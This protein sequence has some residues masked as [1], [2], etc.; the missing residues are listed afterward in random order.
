MP[1]QLA[2]GGD[3]FVVCEEMMST[4]SVEVA[5]TSAGIIWR[6][7]GRCRAQV[8]GGC[9]SEGVECGCEMMRSDGWVEVGNSVSLDCVFGWVDAFWGACLTGMIVQ[10]RRPTD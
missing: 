6:H 3:S 4:G 5:P 7:F 2:F 1:C 8:D 10:T 9:A